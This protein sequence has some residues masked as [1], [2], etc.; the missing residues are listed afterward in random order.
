MIASRKW[1]C[2]ITVLMILAAMHTCVHRLITNHDTAVPCTAMQPHQQQYR[3]IMAALSGPVWHND[4]LSS[5][6]SAWHT[7]FIAVMPC[8]ASRMALVRASRAWRQGMRAIVTTDI[9]QIDALHA[10][11]SVQRHNETFL[12]WPNDH[13]LRSFYEGD[14]RAALAPF[15]VCVGGGVCVCART[16]HGPIHPHTHPDPRHTGI[17]TPENEESDTHI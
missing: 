2:C 12:Y 13:P 5:P 9:D 15:L 3:S 8:T 16:K 1:G 14:S 17:S 11:P 7:R 4:T 10:L 6:A